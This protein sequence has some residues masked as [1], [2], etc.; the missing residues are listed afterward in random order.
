M[1]ILRILLIICF[2]LIGIL[3]EAIL[4]IRIETYYTIKRSEKEFLNKY[5]YEDFSQFKGVY[6]GIRSYDDSGK[7]IITGTI[8]F[9][10]N[11][12]LKFGD[13]TLKMDT[14]DYSIPYMHWICTDKE[15]ELDTIRLKHLAQTFMKYKIPRLHVDTAG[16]VFVY[17]K[18]DAH[19]FVRFANENERLKRSKEYTWKKI[20][21]TDNWYK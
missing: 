19:S 8:E 18:E 14:Q 6:M 4:L 1:K 13:Y 17:I 20:K 7:I 21:N 12:S 3:L 11:D 16:N 10:K 2:L 15:V 5:E 9:L